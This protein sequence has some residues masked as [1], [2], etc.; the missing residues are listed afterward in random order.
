MGAVTVV[1]NVSGP[2]LSVLEE[3]PDGLSTCRADQIAHILPGPTLF[4]LKGRQGH[5][6]FVSVLLH[7]NEHTGFEAIQ[8]VLGHYAGQGLPR[9]MLL[10]IGNIAAAEQNLRTLPDQS[11]YN[12]VWPGTRIPEAREVPMMREVTRIAAEF[13]PFASIDIHNNTGFNPHYACL[14]R[15]EE[16]YLH[17]ARL[18]SRTIVFYTQPVGVQSMAF[19]DICPAVTVECGKS[20]SEASVEHAAEFVSA[21]LS[22][23]HMP[24]HPVPPEDIDLLRTFAVVKVPESAQF[25]FDGSNADFKFR[26]DLDHLNFSECEPGTTFGTLGAET[27]H[28]LDITPGWDGGLLES[29]FDYDG[30]EIR[31]ASDAIPAMLSLDPKAVRLDCLGYLMHRIDRTGHRLLA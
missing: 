30:G 13:K 27:R 7:G 14:N 24:D 17:L 3:I 18:F 28:R 9:D 23:S 29:Y 22:L 5:P 11:D 2:E 21:C 31:L 15:L 8:R 16:P 6:L 20:G 25:S 26:A 10:F 19:S 4:H 1:A 12:R